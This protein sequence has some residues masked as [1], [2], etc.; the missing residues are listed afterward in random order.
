MCFRMFRCIPGLDL[1]VAVIAAFLSLE[2]TAPNVSACVL[3]CSVVSDS[4][5][6]T[7]HSLP[8]SSVHVIS[9]ARI[10]EWVFVSFFKSSPQPRD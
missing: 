9:Q 3:S 2:I 8:G 10:L 1:L 7:D 5:D 6:P 4:L